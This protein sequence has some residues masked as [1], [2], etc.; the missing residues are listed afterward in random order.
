MTEVADEGYQSCWF[1]GNPM[2]ANGERDSDSD[3]DD[4]FEECHRYR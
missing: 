4:D 3:Y 1:H 2:R